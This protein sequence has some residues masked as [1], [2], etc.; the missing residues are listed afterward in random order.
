M[1]KN[2]DFW[3]KLTIGGL[4]GGRDQRSVARWDGEKTRARQAADHIPEHFL[5]V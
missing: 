1:L 4:K 2:F 5:L 3:F